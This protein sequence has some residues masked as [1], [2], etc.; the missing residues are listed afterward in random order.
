MYTFEE[1]GLEGYGLCRLWKNP[2]SAAVSKGTGFSPY[3]ADYRNEG[4]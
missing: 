1:R 3:I 2:M 4:L